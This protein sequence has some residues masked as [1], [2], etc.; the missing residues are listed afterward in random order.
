MPTPKQHVQN[1]LYDLLDDVS[2]EEL[3]LEVNKMEEILRAFE[4]DR[5]EGI[6]HEHVVKETEAWLAKI[7]RRS[8]VKC[9]Q[10]RR[11]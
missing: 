9:A 11:V 8:K 5:G 3:R 4:C 6:P 10:S 2:W 7:R 1:L